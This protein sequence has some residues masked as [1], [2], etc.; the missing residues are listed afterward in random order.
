M[1]ASD[2]GYVRTRQRVKDWMAGPAPILL[3]G[4]VTIAWTATAWLSGPEMVA[5]RW[6]GGLMTILV[7]LGIAGRVMAL[8]L[9][10]LTALLLSLDGITLPGV[11]VVM[12]SL[13]LAVTGSGPLSLWRVDE[14]LVD[15]RI[16]NPPEKG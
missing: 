6:I 13:S 12:G 5:W 16:G 8:A 15:L 11:M 4:L 10:L 2:P 7:L 3:R 1:L 14:R 9:A